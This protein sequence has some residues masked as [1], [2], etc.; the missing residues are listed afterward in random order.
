[1]KTGVPMWGGQSS[2]L[3]S[4]LRAGLPTLHGARG[5]VRIVVSAMAALMTMAADWPQWGGPGRDFQVDA[6][7]LAS[8]WPPGGPKRLWSRPLGDGYSA[9]LAEGAR[10]Y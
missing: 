6:P 9:I 10:L 3:E 4:R 8:S 1:M 2:R 5:L 7:A